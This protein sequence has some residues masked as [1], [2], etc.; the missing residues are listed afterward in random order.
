MFL[1]GNLCIRYLEWDYPVDS[2]SLQADLQWISFVLEGALW[3][4]IYLFC[5][6][7]KTLYNNHKFFP[8]QC[9]INQATN[10]TKTKLADNMWESLL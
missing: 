4:I 1:I 9:V 10:D 7:W 6:M 8:V 2:S 3:K 5:K